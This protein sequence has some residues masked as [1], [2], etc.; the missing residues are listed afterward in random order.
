MAIGVIVVTY[1]SRDVILDCLESLVASENADLRI[2]VVDNASQD[3][4]VSTIREWASME[5]PWNGSG[6]PF[7]PLPHGPIPLYESRD[8]IGG[9]PIGTIAVLSSATN[10][11]FAGGV[12]LGIETLGHIDDV[13]YL[14]VLNPDCMVENRTAMTLWTRAETAGRFGIIGG[15]IYYNSPPE[16]IQ[17]D[18]GRV[19]PWTGKCVPFN[20]T[21]IGRDVPAP[22][23][24]D[25]DYVSGAHMLVSREFVAQVGLMSENYFLYFEEV[26]WCLRRGDFPLLFCKDAA[27]H[28]YGGVSIGSP[29]ML[30]GPSP[31]SAYFM[32]RSRL[33]FMWR[34]YPAAIPLSL[35]YTALKAVTTIARGGRGAGFASLRGLFGFPP[36]EEMRR[37]LGKNALISR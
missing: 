28:H 10:R 22:K 16:A 26:D 32:A 14:W 5:R 36:S 33:R 7:T 31:L 24:A 12:N 3:D 11:G 15:R 34:F 35:L 30:Q 23:E 21:R 1:N 9:V 25:L 4:T 29:T 6:K 18:G 17:S 20:R 2:L 37:K 27:V 8:R 19:N 13:R